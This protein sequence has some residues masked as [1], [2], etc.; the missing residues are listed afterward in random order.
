MHNRNVRNRAA[1]GQQ[2]PL[3]SPWPPCF[4]G[5][6]CLQE[7]YDLDVG[8]SLGGRVARENTTPALTDTPPRTQVL[9]AYAYVYIP[10]CIYIYIYIYRYIYLY[11]IKDETRPSGRGP[12]RRWPGPA[13]AARKLQRKPPRRRL[14]SGVC[15][16]LEPGTSTSPLFPDPCKP[17]TTSPQNKPSSLEPLQ[18]KHTHT[19]KHQPSKAWAPGPSAGTPC[20]PPWRRPR[21]CWLAAADRSRGGAPVGEGEGFQGVFSLTKLHESLGPFFPSG[22]RKQCL[23]LPAHSVAFPSRRLQWGLRV[24]S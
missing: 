8:S 16:I 7:L 21:R 24:T 12:R 18:K 23:G 9:V 13:A 20:A 17:Y 4:V 10:V 2:Q 6:A 11:L 15:E 19:N 3:A 22:L 5:R 14:L 1:S